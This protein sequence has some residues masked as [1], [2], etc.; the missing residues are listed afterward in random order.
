[1]D[2]GLKAFEQE[3]LGY[4]A[5]NNGVLSDQEI[6]FWEGQSPS[7]EM[8]RLIEHSKNH[9]ARGLQMRDE[10]RM[11][12]ERANSEKEGLISNLKDTQ[13]ALETELKREQ[14][15]V[16]DLTNAQTRQYFSVF[17]LLCVTA[18]TVYFFWLD[19]SKTLSESSKGLG[20]TLLPVLWTVGSFSILESL[21]SKK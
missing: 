18:I 14:K 10:Q 5:Q 21:F 4:Y 1:M 6:G 7:P 12:L 20:T 9:L 15:N 13:S 17:Y 16:I 8:V 19:T 2:E 11:K 3:L